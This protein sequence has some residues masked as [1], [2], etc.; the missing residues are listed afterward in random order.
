MGL[1]RYITRKVI[2][3]ILLLLMVVAF[4]FVLFQI[5]PFAFACPNLSYEQCAS[6][7][8]VPQNPPPKI[9]N[10]TAWKIEVQDK[11]LNAYGFNKPIWVRFL[12]YYVNMFTANFGYNIG[13]V[14][15]GSVIQ[16]IQQRTPFTLLLLGTSTIAAFIIGIGLGVLA[17]AKRGK[18][19][20][21]SSLSVLLFLNSLPV[22]FLGS[23]LWIFQLGLLHKDYIPVGSELSL[24]G[25]WHAYADIIRALWLPFVTLTVAGIGGVFLTQRAVMI[26][27]MGEDYVVMARAKGVPERTVLYKHGLRNAVLPIVTAFAL[28]IGFI[29]SGAIITE[30]IFQWP[31]LGYAT[32]QAVTADDFPFAQ[33]IF[34]IITVCV[35]VAIFAA[36]ITYGFLDPRVSRD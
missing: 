13:N 9:I 19:I 5:L 15:G 11:I 10:I 30:T 29:L 12:D 20:D 3:S 36:D 34:F 6:K 16:T 18:V 7:L 32:F 23:M 21:I 35:L 17:S 2:Y 28:S 14:L 27:T 25:G 8:Y 31:G 22:F 1:R 26:D 33:A 4:N 24:V